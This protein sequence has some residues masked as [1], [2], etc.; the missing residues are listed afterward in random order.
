[1]HHDSTI[2]TTS[3]HPRPQFARD[4]WIDL[5]GRWDVAFGEEPGARFIM[6]LTAVAPSDRTIEVPFPP[7]SERSGIGEDGHTVIWYR[8]EWDAARPAPGKRVLLHFEGVDHEA[9]VWINGVHVTSHVGGQTGF[10]VDITDA[11]ADAGRQVIAVRAIDSTSLEQPRGKQDWEPEPHVIW[12]RRTS[13]IWRPVWA[14]V[15]DAVHVESI[16]WIPG[17]LPG[18]LSFDARI[19]GA[20]RAAAAE[21]ELAFDVP[22]GERFRVACSVVDGRAAG[23]ITLSDPRLDA[24][25]DR[26]RWSPE[27]PT[28]IDVDVVLRTDGVVTDEVRSYVGLRTVATDDH[29]FLLNGRP[30]FLRLVLEQAYWPESHLAAPSDDAIRRE[31]ELIKA[32][33]FNGLRMHQV[34]PDPRFLYWCDRLGLLVWEDAAAAYRYSERALS[35]TTTEWMEIV[36]R[37][38][39]HP[40]V[41]AWVAFNESW[42]VPDLDSS[43]TQRH[44]VTALYHLIKALDPSR[45]VI[46]NDGWEFVAGDL[47]GIHDYTQDPAVLAER[48]GS[49]AATNDTIAVGRPGG[50]RLAVAGSAAQ[51]LPV[52]LSEFGGATLSA[53]QSWEGYGSVGDSEALLERIAGLIGALNADGLAGYCYTQLTDTVQEANGILTEDRTP[54]VDVEAFSNILRGTA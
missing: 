32:L 54:K 34:T 6:G 48:Y 40:S 11:L 38:R 43:Q 46:G 39:S 12:Y 18:A 21:L 27:R 3:L 17:E 8:R 16:A 7:E 1:M 37:D 30:Y 5:N 51:H 2:D 49:R 20:D 50:R 19:V 10:H 31:V 23:A 52:V 26:L 42:G 22:G 41:V 28:L 13:G 25:P 36:H 47:L 29:A 35:R 15:V 4:R 24:E 33:G 9:D 45:P 44:A 14:E 53:E